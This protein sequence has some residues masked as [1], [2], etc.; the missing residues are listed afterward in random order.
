[1]LR[2]RI[3]MVKTEQTVEL[4]LHKNCKVQGSLAMQEQSAAQVCS[5]EQQVR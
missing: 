2:D 3:Q 5:E 4:V 1:M